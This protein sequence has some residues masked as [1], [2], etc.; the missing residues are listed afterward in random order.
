MVKDFVIFVLIIYSSYETNANFK[1]PLARCNTVHATTVDD[2][3]CQRAFNFMKTIALSKKSKVRAGKYQT[4]IDDEDFDRVN[5]WGW[6][7]YFKKGCSDPK[8]ACRR[9][10]ING[11]QRIIYLHRFILNI[12]DPSVIIDHIDGNGLNN[13]KINLRICSNTENTRNSKKSNKSYSSIYKGVCRAKPNSKRYSAQITVNR[14]KLHLGMFENEE[15]AAKSYDLAAIK[16]FGQFAKLNFN[17][18]NES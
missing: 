4:L 12:T 6:L 10:N 3:S 9:K 15:D 7:A 1:T 8:Y 13:Q 16:H 5:K 2:P 11:G 17:T 14:K 18:T